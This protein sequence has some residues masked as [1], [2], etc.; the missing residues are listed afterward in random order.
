MT[1]LRAWLAD[2]LVEALRPF[3]DAS[4]RDLLDRLR[5]DVTIR[6]HLEE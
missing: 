6:F 4:T 5:V 2:Q 3:V 1:S